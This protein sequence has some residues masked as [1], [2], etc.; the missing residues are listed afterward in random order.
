M[1]RCFLLTLMPSSRRIR[2]TRFGLT[3][4]PSRRNAPIA[5]ARMLVAEFQH[6][7]AEAPAL[8]ARLYL[9]IQPGS[10]QTQRTASSRFAPRAVLHAPLGSPPFCRRAYHFFE[11]TFFR[12]W[13]CTLRSAMMRLSRAFARSHPPTPANAAPRSH[14]SLHTCASTHSRC[15]R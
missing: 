8:H 9:A 2:A 3:S 11:L 6:L 4:K 5:V 1:R 15:L 14:P 12:M 13:F 7:L 10:G